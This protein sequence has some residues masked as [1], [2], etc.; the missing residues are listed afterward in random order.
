M[1]KQMLVSE[2]SPGM[3]VTRVIEQAGAVKIRKVGFIRS[4]D[5]I[6]GLTEMGV[7]M[8]EVDLDQSL[9]AEPELEAPELNQSLDI[10]NDTTP[11]VTATQRLVASTKQVAD[12]DRQLSQQFHRSLFLPAVDQMPSKWTLYGKPYA[13]LLAFIVFGLL[14]GGV[15]SYALMALSTSS[16]P[17]VVDATEIPSSKSSVDLPTDQMSSQSAPNQNSR[18]IT[19]INDL[20][21]LVQKNASDS[22][23]GAQS[24]AETASSEAA[25]RPAVASE[26]NKTPVPTSEIN[27]PQPVEREFVNG[28]LLEAGQQV[29]GYQGAES[30]ESDVPQPQRSSNQESQSQFSQ[31][32]NSQNNDTTNANAPRNSSATINDDYINSD[33][34]NRIQRV[35][36]DVDSQPTEPKPQLVKVT[37]L[38]DLPR[39]DQLS[40]ALLT[41]MPAMSFSAHMYASNPQD[42]W[43]RVNSRR[44]S[45]GDTIANNV[46]LK[47]IEAEKVVLE[48]NG[49]E[50]TMN[51]LSDW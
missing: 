26:P 4:P 14:V 3:M 27:E 50:F 35:A 1:L 40:P 42:R 12:A 31:N 46:L 28:V 16:E 9:H 19:N 44:L 8:V 22:G 23:T 34:F 47:R 18:K 2:L 43:V 25:S 11:K 37:N 29:L 21:P 32:S 6:K 5:M 38:N 10:Q 48:Y 41:Q 39:I 13:V 17:K 33:L 45:E 15:S 30:K 20:S 49:K 51:A 24:R 7:T 36:K